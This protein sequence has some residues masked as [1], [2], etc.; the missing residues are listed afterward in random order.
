[1]YNCKKFTGSIR[2]K[3]FLNGEQ[4]I[5]NS[6]FS[7]TDYRNQGQRVHNNMENCWIH[8]FPNAISHVEDTRVAGSISYIDNRYAK[9]TMYLSILN[10]S[11]C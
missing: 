10:L 6:A 4:L 11:T 3:I 8:V 1:M 7:L 9:S 2:H 5:L